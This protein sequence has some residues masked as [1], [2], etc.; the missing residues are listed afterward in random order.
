MLALVSASH[1][2]VSESRTDMFLKRALR[3]PKPWGARVGLAEERT[4][5][6]NL[7]DL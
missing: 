1:Y 3:P 6:A 7:H 4:M 5:V 2:V